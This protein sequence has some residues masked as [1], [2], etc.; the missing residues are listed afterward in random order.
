MKRIQVLSVTIDTKK[1]ANG[2]DYNIA[3]VAFKNLSTGKVEAKKILSY[4][5]IYSDVAGF[6]GGQIF[7]V[8]DEK[9]GTTG[10]WD[11]VSVTRVLDNDVGMVKEAST[12]RRESVTPTRSTYE[13]PEER[14]QKQVYIVKQ[15]SL[16][17]A[18]E[19]FK[20]N[21]PKGAI[22]PDDVITMAQGFVDWVFETP[23]LSLE[24]VP[25]DLPVDVE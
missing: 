18:V 12:A 17:S 5:K 15:S 14:A 22:N 1:A 13:T 21:N 19:V 6:A 8:V 2:K 24:S 20:H 23:E 7:D 11:W 16:S 10:Y 25:N 3:E 9:N 4:S